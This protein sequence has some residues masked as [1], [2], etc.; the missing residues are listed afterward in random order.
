MVLGPQLL[1][2][3]AFA[4]QVPPA[5]AATLATPPPGLFAP[6]SARGV[7]GVVAH[8]P[9]SEPAAAVIRAEIAGGWTG[10]RVLALARVPPMAPCTDAPYDAYLDVSLATW[11]GTNAVTT[12][13]GIELYDCAGW[14]VDQWHEQRTTAAPLGPSAA[15][16]LAFAALFRLRTWTVEQKALADALF[17][18]GLAFVAGTSAPTYFYTLY[19]TDD[20]YM[21]AFVRPGGPAY[22]AGLRTGDVVDKVDGRFWWEYGTYQTQQRAYDG[23]PHVF[24]VTRGKE[25]LTVR[26]GAPMQ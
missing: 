8:D 21:R 1:G 9:A 6:A 16:Q 24:E 7:V 18:N 20:G 14:S 17:T 10:F 15:A 13:T 4:W 5:Q 25:T 19:K 2:V 12:D 11:R 26:L 22:A 3:R 23:K